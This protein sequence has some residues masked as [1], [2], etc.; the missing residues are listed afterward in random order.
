MNIIHCYTDLYPGGAAKVLV[1]MANIMASDG[2]NVIVLAG[3]GKLSNTINK[4][5]DYINFDLGLNKNFI[6]AVFSYFKVFFRFLSIIKKN[7]VELIF[8]HHRYL[9]PLFY[10]I[11]KL[12]KIKVVFI[13]HATSEKLFLNFDFYGNKIWAVSET[14]KNHFIKK[15]HVNQNKIEVILNAIEK[16]DKISV[17][18]INRV[19]SE[20][21][22]S[23]KKII[24]CVAHFRKIKRQEFLIDAFKLSL[25]NSAN[26]VLI[27][28][29]FGESEK[30]LN[31]K[32]KKHELSDKVFIISKKYSVAQILSI[33]HLLVLPSSREGLGLSI[34]EGFSIGIPAV[35]TK[36]TGMEEI[37]SHGYNG[38]LFDADSLSSL[39]F[40][41]DLVLK[42]D[43][44]YKRLCKNAQFTFDNK[45]NPKK[46]KLKLIELL[47]K[48]TKNLI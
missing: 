38:Y 14:V 7:K 28:Y 45:F 18:E 44:D 37:I 35:G 20:L 5:V 31:N 41:L 6:T 1:N 10:F 3:D 19:K 40:Y 17:E 33:S 27:L 13:A 2:H 29:G 12:T 15:L 11:Q 42:D 30:D 32:I 26:I 21:K 48:E 8:N 24:T 16:V 34:L 25:K 9:S 43:Q 23:E 46:Y 39:E 22:I 47:N 36:G 4:E